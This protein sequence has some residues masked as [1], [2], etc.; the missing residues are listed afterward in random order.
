[1]EKRGTYEKR[2]PLLLCLICVISSL[3]FMS[4]YRMPTEEDYSVVPSINNPDYTRE[5]PN[6]QMIPNVG[7]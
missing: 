5:K 6:N 2:N 1:M 3:N 4:C 7:F